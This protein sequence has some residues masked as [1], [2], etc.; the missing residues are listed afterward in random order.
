MILS[1]YASISVKCFWILLVIGGVLLI[2]FAPV[3]NPNKIISDQK[4]IQYKVISLV[5][6]IT[7]C[8]IG[9]ILNREY[10]IISNVCFYTLCAD[11]ILI[12]PKNSKNK[13]KE[14]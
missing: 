10:P 3:K 7:F 12:F 11:I 4:S 9:Y 2:V 1:N 8:V 14:M 5:L 13:R 6:F